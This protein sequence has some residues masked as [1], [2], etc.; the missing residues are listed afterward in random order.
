M[1]KKPNSTG[2]ALSKSLPSDRP[3]IR[4]LSSQLVITALVI[5][6]VTALLTVC[7]NAP[8]PDREAS[9]SARWGSAA[10]DVAQ[11][12]AWGAPVDGLRCRCVPGATAVA[13]GMKP[14]LRA[15][16]ENASGQ[17][18]FWECGSEISWGFGIPG[19]CGKWSMPKFRVRVG[20]GARPATAR[21]VG[22][23]FGVGRPDL[24]GDDAFAGEDWGYFCIEPGGQIVL[25][26]TLPWK[27]EKPGQ[28]QVYCAIARWNPLSSNA[29]WFDEGW[30]TCPTV[31]LKI[32]DGQR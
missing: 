20:R 18:I 11:P 1:G 5:L 3:M 25:I 24:K 15:V 27:F 4:R 8:K 28:Y 13:K 10:T 22:E 16:V 2:S 6:A 14:E 32:V 19:V 26:S 17:P 9:G 21:E 29:R 12:S 30:M 31:V 23:R 7:R